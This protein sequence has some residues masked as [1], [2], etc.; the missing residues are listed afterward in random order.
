GS[1]GGASAGMGEPQLGESDR[2]RVTV[3]IRHPE[4]AGAEVEIAV[5]ENF[6]DRKLKC[7]GVRRIAQRAAIGLVEELPEHRESRVV[8]NRRRIRVAVIEAERLR[9]LGAPKLEG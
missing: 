8:R 3:G 2:C 7:S 9:E 5:D 1:V 4:A 6:P